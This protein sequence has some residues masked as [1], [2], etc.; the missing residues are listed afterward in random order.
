M[1][2][3]L[4]NFNSVCS[5][6]E[7]DNVGSPALTSRRLKYVDFSSFVSQVELIDL[8]LLGIKFIWFQPKVKFICLSCKKSLTYSFVFDHCPIIL[9]YTNKLWGFKLLDL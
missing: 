6:I 8:P 2:C 1:W 3:I 9:I 7:R 4:E 5:S